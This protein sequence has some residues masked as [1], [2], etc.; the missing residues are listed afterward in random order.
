MGHE[1]R[2]CGVGRYSHGIV[3]LKRHPFGGLRW[4]DNVQDPK[5]DEMDAEYFWRDVLISVPLDEGVMHKEPSIGSGE[6]CVAVG[7]PR[8][9]ADEVMCSQL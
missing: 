8:K 4:P 2:R 1:T 3:I 5:V 7:Q 9:Q 6:A